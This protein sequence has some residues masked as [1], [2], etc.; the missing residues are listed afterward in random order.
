MKYS[1]SILNMQGRE[2]VEVANDLKGNWRLS[3]IH[4]RV[5]TESFTTSRLKWFP[6]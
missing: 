2:L 1:K 5:V 3:S 4:L 6:S